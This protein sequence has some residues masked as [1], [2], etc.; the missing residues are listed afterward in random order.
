MS[1]CN[2]FAEEKK[3]CALRP[4]PKRAY[5]LEDQ[6]AAMDWDLTG[7]STEVESLKRS[8]WWHRAAL[9]IITVAIAWVR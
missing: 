8:R 2:E 5:T 7:L 6:V 3:L 9:V 4:A 1:F